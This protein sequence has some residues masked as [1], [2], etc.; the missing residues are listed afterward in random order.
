MV[1]M[2]RIKGKLIYEK[3]VESRDLEESKFQ[4]QIFKGSH[5]GD[6]IVEA[7]VS[8]QYRAKIRAHNAIKISSDIFN[9]KLR[10]DK[11]RNIGF[12]RSE[13]HFKSI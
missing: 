13:I 10:V 1:R 4:E 7:R 3:E 8:P 6:I 9:K 2:I 12:N 5:K 11:I